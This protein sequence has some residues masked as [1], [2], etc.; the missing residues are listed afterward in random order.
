MDLCENK[1]A[2]TSAKQFLEDDFY[3]FYD[4]FCHVTALLI[5][6]KG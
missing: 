2:I 6:G 5:T 4:I 1:D 3:I